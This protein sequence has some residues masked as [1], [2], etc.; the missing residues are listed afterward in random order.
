[1]LLCSG[2]H[3]VSYDIELFTVQHSH[4]TPPAS[5]FMNAVDISEYA[6]VFK[7]HAF[8]G[9]GVCVFCLFPASYTVLPAFFETQ[10]SKSLLP[11][12]IRKTERAIH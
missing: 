2:G 3:Y 11:T 8:V 5:V 4:T 7:I 6:D 12:L 9:V 1:M 10:K